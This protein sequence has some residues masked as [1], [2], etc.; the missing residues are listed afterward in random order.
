MFPP[1][2]CIHYRSLAGESTHEKPRILEVA[3]AIQNM[4][5]SEEWRE[6]QAKILKKSKEVEMNARKME[7]VLNQSRYQGHSQSS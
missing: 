4:N 6:S 7:V 5:K 3:E 1:C 2:F